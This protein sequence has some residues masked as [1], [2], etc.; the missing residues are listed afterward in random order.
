MT[1]RKL[2]AVGALQRTAVYSADESGLPHRSVTRYSFPRG[3]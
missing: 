1:H 3:W 2:E